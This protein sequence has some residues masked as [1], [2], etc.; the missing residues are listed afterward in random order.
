MTLS[1]KGSRKIVVDEE[2]YRW[3]ISATSK[4]RIVLITEHGQ[5]K[6]QRIEVYIES[7]INEFW[8]EFP[9]VDDLNLKIVKP[10]EVAVII[11]KAIEQGWRSKEKGAPIV[12]DWFENKLVKR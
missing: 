12:F 10:K 1:K 2:E 6:G 7:D 9:Y 8:V 3:I 5:E 11:T 4:G